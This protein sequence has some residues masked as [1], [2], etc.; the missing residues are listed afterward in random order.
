[1]VMEDE[2]GKD[3]KVLAVLTKDPRMG[4]MHTLRDVPEHIL[5]EIS[6][7]FEQ[8]KVMRVCVC[9]CVCRGSSR[10]EGFEGS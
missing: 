2:K 4:E 1:M 5:R 3:E 6:C 8:Y 10:S 7:F 9:V